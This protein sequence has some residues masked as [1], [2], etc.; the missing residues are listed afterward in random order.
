M[1]DQDDRTPVSR[2]TRFQDPQL[3]QAVTDPERIVRTASRAVMP[4]HTPADRDKDNSTPPDA[5]R[6]SDSQESNRLTDNLR[7]RFDASIQE[8]EDPLQTDIG[9]AT[10]PGNDEGQH[11]AAPVLPEIDLQTHADEATDNR[12]DPDLDAIR[13][14]EIQDLRANVQTLQTI[15]NVLQSDVERQAEPIPGMVRRIEGRS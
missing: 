5:S 15:M 7:R 10:L 8:T 4:A 14:R 9:T 6:S 13:D 12:E 2:R 3:T 11:E 1:D